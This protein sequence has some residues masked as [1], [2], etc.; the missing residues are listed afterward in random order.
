MPS[1][2][3]TSTVRSHRRGGAPRRFSVA[4]RLIIGSVVLL[5]VAGVS[6]VLTYVIKGGC[7]GTARA[8]VIVTPRVQPIMQQLSTAWEQTQPSV[9]G[10]CGS[11]TIVAKESAEVAA[12]L[13]AGWDPT[14][15]GEAPDV[16][17][18]DASAW[19]RKASAS[20]VA[21]RLIPDLQPSLARTP[22]V[23]AM[24]KQLS[25][26]AGMTAKALTWQQII[27][28]M[29][30]SG[31]WDF[32]KHPEWGGFKVGLSDPQASTAGLLA[33]LAIS[34]TD[35]DGEVE[36][37]EQTNLL[38]LKKVVSLT[39]PSTDAIFDGLRSAAGQDAK[40]ALTYVSAFP[41]LERDVLHYNLDKP[42]IP[43]V[44]VYPQDGTAEADFPYLILRDTTWTTRERSDVAAAFLK[45]VRG[46][47]G[48]AAFLDAGFRDPNRSPG[49]DLIPANGVATKITALPRAVLLPES[50]QR[51]AASW[52]AVTRPTNVLFIFDTSGSMAE[53]V[54]GTGKSRLDLTKTAAINALDLLNGT[55]KVGVWDFSTTSGAEDY[56]KLLPLAPLDKHAGG[57][58][59]RDEVS[60][61]IEA[62][63]PG[64]NT[65][66]YNTVWS[67]CQEVSAAHEANAA[68]FVVLLTDGADDNN[69]ASSLTLEQLVKNLRAT[70]RGATPVQIITVGLGDEAQ[71]TV[72]RE[73]S[74]ATDAPTYA[75]AKSFDINQVLLSFL[76]D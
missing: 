22:T 17:V 46:S 2:G 49:P 59:H 55:A 30:A 3:R 36:A 7:S 58:T 37:A 9:N 10:I 43:L 31:G 13:G 69:I 38:A 12:D 51:A 8:N 76:F 5:A 28:K 27:D 34:D 63:I 71:S 6:A 66:L 74:A 73:I 54:Q 72:L 52:T 62:L 75:S 57:G 70:C 65:G 33:L 35:D 48:R 61:T 15:M 39:P 24:P 47:Q 29:S 32:Y 19:V 16:W 25:G 21:E 14:S 4:P 42:M 67:A 44:A 41:A 23:I 68:N 45:Y 20:A 40:Q 18:P 1:Y 53:E 56:R 64:G 26:A 60:Q 11:V 50:V